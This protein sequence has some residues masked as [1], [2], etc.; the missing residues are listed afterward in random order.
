MLTILC[1]ESPSRVPAILPHKMLHSVVRKIVF[2]S[3]TLMSQEQDCT[4][5]LRYRNSKKVIFIILLMQNQKL[6]CIDIYSLR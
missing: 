3:Q 5:K 1:G 2:A 4:S 6:K